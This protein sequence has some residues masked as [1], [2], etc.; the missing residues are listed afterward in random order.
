MH[1]TWTWRCGSGRA[2]AG[3]SNAVQARPSFCCLW[4]DATL[5][6]ALLRPEILLY[7]DN[8]NKKEAQA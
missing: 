5:D 8:N 3:G 7:P 1:T 6:P 2:G 4:A